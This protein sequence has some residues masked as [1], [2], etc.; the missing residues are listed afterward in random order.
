MGMK[1]LDIVYRKEGV[2]FLLFYPSLSSLILT[3]LWRMEKR[4]IKNIGRHW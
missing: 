1:K 4:K 2:I 3:N